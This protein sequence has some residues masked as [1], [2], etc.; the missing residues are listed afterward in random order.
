MK[1]NL[2]SVLLSLCIF[3]FS[4]TALAQTRQPTENELK[5]AYCLA[6]NREWVSEF[7]KMADEGAVAT[8]A[9]AE[10]NV[11][12]LQSFLSPRM[13]DFE[14]AAFRQAEQNGVRDLQTAKQKFNACFSECPSKKRESITAF[15]KCVQDCERTDENT[16]TQLCY[17]ANLINGL[18]SRP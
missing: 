5:A 17:Q 4:A 9:V 6:V 13:A 15:I 2:L 11:T 10:A 8:R 7:G 1:R 3:S 16:K 12:R 18:L 14:N